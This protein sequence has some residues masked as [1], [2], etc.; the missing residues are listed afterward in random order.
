MMEQ[1]TSH[2]LLVDHRDENRYIISSMLAP[3]YNITLLHAS[4]YKKAL[5]QLLKHPCSVIL[6]NDSSPD[7]DMYDFAS[8]ISNNKDYKQIPIIML[9]NSRLNA[10]DCL[11]IYQAGIIDYISHPIEPLTLIN[12]VNQFVVLHDSLARASQLK[13]QRDH[14]LNAANQGVIEVNAQGVIQYAN[15]KAC[16]LLQCSAS[17]I[18]Y[19]DFNNWFSKK[20]NRHNYVD[21]FN[22]L[23]RQTKQ[24]GIYHRTDYLADSPNNHSIPLEMT[25]IIGTGDAPSAMTL[26]FQDISAQL[27]TEK[28]LTYL[29]NC[30]PLTTLT[31]RSA[32]LDSLATTISR[33]QQTGSTVA[34]LILNLDDFKQIN[35]SLGHETGDT[36]LKA[37]SQRLKD[38]LKED[39]IVARLG[40]DEF[41]II[42]KEQ[43]ANQISSTCLAKKVIAQIEKTYFVN[44]QQIT[45]GSSVGIAFSH[46]GKTSAK[47]LVKYA[48]IA[49]HEAKSA[50]RSIYEV[51][52]PTMLEKTTRRLF[53][54]HN[55]RQAIKNKALILHYQPQLS[56]SKH[57]L[58]GFEA[59]LRWVPEDGEAISP[60]IF[61]PI[62]EQS[63]LIH[64]LGIYIL[65]QVCAKL[66]SWQ[67]YI[68]DTD[69]SISINISAKQ[70]NSPKFVNTVQSITSQYI[71][72]PA[73]LVLEI[74]ETAIMDDTQQVIKTL[75][76]LKA[77]GF[78]IAL[79]DFGTGYSSLSYL[80]AMPIDRLKIDQC[81]VKQL[82]SSPKNQALIKAMMAIADTFGIDV[83]AE[84]AENI[85]QLF[86][87]KS[88]GCD[89]IQGFFFSKALEPERAEK[90]L[91]QQKNS[92]F[93]QQFNLLNQHRKASGL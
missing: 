75:E 36:L 51:Y 35:D 73:Q 27:A 8:L 41:A 74:T 4:S 45:I 24:K 48:D 1:A 54:E 78:R 22:R 80:Q 31:N 77:L 6:L 29:T 17:Q 25:C 5:S 13:D 33:S 88:L 42:T 44:S 76:E 14:I 28:K 2:V 18:I 9:A 46:Q 89:I 55:L 49:L 68:T 71:F 12:K 61:I 67:P 58:T 72:K 34:L 64:E 81:F 11:K 3:L 37:I 21:S 38:T 63:R 52:K 92:V 23:Y 32:F 90:L 53:I 59:L 19:S 69:F 30:D 60:A 26:L 43:M 84:G 56:M 16:Q 66:Q 93:S 62:A 40:G 39:D 50:G 47:D 10:D 86:S 83:I 87:L 79:D 15:T 85:S 70:L 91:A 20:D 7:M 65:E 82:D 57:E